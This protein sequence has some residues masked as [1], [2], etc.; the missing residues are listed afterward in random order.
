MYKRAK[1]LRKIMEV[2]EEK[3]ARVAIPT[4]KATCPV[5]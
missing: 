5:F 4:T 1:L 3:L 2:L